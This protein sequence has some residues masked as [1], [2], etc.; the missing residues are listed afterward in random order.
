MAEALAVRDK[1]GPSLKS[2]KVPSD[3]GF[4]DSPQTLASTTKERK[5]LLY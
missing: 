4:V 2:L 3:L 5:A 1:L